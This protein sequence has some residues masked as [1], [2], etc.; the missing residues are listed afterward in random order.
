[1]MLLRTSNNPPYTPDGLAPIEFYLFPKLNIPLAVRTFF[2][3]VDRMPTH[4]I[5][6]HTITLNLNFFNFYN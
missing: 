6:S 2:T 4:L 5:F 1:M 3:V